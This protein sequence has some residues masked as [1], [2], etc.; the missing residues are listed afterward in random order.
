MVDAGFQSLRAFLL[1]T[2]RVWESLG[3]G[4]RCPVRPSWGTQAAHPHWQLP[5]ATLAAVH[6]GYVASTSMHVSP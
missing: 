4:V 3:C 5:T 1:E 2:N 6:Q